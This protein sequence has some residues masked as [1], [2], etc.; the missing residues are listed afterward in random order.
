[1]D[2][3]TMFTA[4]V[5]L[6]YALLIENPATAQLSLAIN[7][8]I[9]AA[10]LSKSSMNSWQ[11]S[12]GILASKRLNNFD[13]YLGITYSFTAQPY[14][15]YSQVDATVGTGIGPNERMFLIEDTL[16]T[17]NFSGSIFTSNQ[18]TLSFS[19]GLN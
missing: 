2:A 8:G 16:Q 9:K 11:Y 15:D 7:A 10:C 6:K 18:T 19:I 13:P 14:G 3:L 1:M 4:G 5:G 12:L 17:I